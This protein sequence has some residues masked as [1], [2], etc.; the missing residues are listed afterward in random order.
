MRVSEKLW[1]TAISELFQ[2]VFSSTTAVHMLLGQ[3]VCSSIRSPFP[4]TICTG[5]YYF[6]TLF[7]C[8][9]YWTVINDV[10]RKYLCYTGSWNDVQFPDEISKYVDASD[11]EELRTLVE[12]IEQDEDTKLT[13]EAS[14]KICRVIARCKEYLRENSRT[15]KLW[16]QYLHYVINTV[17]QFISAGCTGNWQNYLMV[18]RQMLILFSS[19][20][21]FQNAKSARFYLQLIDEL[22]I[23]FPWLHNL[24]QQGY[25]AIKRS[26]RYWARL[27]T[28]LA[29]EMSLMRTVKSCERLKCWI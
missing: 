6:S 27:L 25:Y 14:L 26:D 20:V 5:T 15:A 2:V 16:I 12:Q 7:T 8:Y 4:G 3:Y 19:T 1:K 9:F 22:P 18:V 28:D 10:E 21:H 13:R 29:I 11:T 17:K 23:D 24:F